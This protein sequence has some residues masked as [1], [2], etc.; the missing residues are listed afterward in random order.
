MVCVRATQQ[1]REAN[2]AKTYFSTQGVVWF[3]LRINLWAVEPDKH[4][5]MVS[6]IIESLGLTSTCESLASPKTP[7]GEPLGGMSPVPSGW[8]DLVLIP[9]D[10]MKPRPVSMAKSVSCR[11]P[12][13]ID[14]ERVWI[15]TESISN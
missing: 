10:S 14:G 4:Q 12:K 2:S 6:I 11:T 3:V 8:C 15:W 13:K 9:N 7:R 5:G 1:D